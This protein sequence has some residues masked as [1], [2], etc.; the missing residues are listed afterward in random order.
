MATLNI[1]KEYPGEIKTITSS[2]GEV[3]IQVKDLIA[4]SRHLEIESQKMTEGFQNVEYKRQAYVYQQVHCNYA[5]T[6]EKIES[7]QKRKWSQNKKKH[8]LN[9]SSGSVYRPTPFKEMLIPILVLLFLLIAL[10][11]LAD[12]MFS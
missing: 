3:F 12:L 1:K 11:T 7:V 2:E 8:D 4:F 5:L 9:N 10:G 6:L